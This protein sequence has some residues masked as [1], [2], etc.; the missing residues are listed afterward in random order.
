MSPERRV[1]LPRAIPV[2]AATPQRKVIYFNTIDR[3][4]AA[5]C[6]Q[7]GVFG[8]DAGNL[9]AMRGTESRARTASRLRRKRSIQAGSF[10]AGTRLWGSLCA[11]VKHPS[12]GTLGRSLL[13]DVPENATHGLKSGISNGLAEANTALNI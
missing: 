12:Q 11:A 1:S 7:C 10:T 3:I 2:R 5:R 4:L 13:S 8:C 9:V 6:S